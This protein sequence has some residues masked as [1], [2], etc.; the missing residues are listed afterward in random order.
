MIKTDVGLICVI[1][2]HK[3]NAGLGSEVSLNLDFTQP[4]K[5][6]RKYAFTQ[7]LYTNYADMK[8]LRRKYVDI[9]QVILGARTLILL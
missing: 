4:W 6:R 5:L 1:E 7:K 9:A 8:W 3:S 2:F